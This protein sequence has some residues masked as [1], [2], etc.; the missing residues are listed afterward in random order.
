M[1]EAIAQLGDVGGEILIDVRLV[2]KIDHETLILRV[3]VLHQIEGRHIHCLA[4][5][6]HGAG[7]VDQNAERYGNVL[8]LKG[9]N[10]LGHAI[11]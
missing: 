3:R 5:G 4:L 6:A 11:F 8:M 7:V 9:G 10:G 1:G 2:G